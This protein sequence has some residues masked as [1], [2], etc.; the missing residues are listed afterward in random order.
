MGN[1]KPKNPIFPNVPKSMDDYRGW[2]GLAS[3]MRNYLSGF[4]VDRDAPG[5]ITLATPTAAGVG[6]QLHWT[7]TPKAT[8]YHVLRNDSNNPTSALVISVLPGRRNVSFFDP[9]GSSTTAATLYYWIQPFN[10]NVAGPFSNMG[11]IGNPSLPAGGQLNGLPFSSPLGDGRHGS[12]HITTNTT[13]TSEIPIYQVTDLTIDSGVTWTAYA[14]NPGGFYISCT[15]RVTIEGTLTAA[16]RG[17]LGGRSVTSA[18][19]GYHG[20][21]GWNISGSG[22]G[23]G[24]A[25]SGADQAGGHG[26]PCKSGI[27]MTGWSPGDTQRDSSTSTSWFGNSGSPTNNEVRH[28]SGGISNPGGV[29]GLNSG[30]NGTT[31]NSVA[32]GMAGYG[33]TD[34]F[35]ILWASAPGLVYGFG[36]GGG[37]GGLAGAGT[38]SGAGGNGGGIIVILC[39]EFDF[40]ASGTISVAGQNGSN[41]VAAAGQAAGGGGG[42][43]G[44]LIVGYRTLISNV[45]TLTK[46]GGSAGTGA[47]G[48]AQGGAGGD[49]FSKVFDMRI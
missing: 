19:Y 18:G 27:V 21:P 47:L 40:P 44:L 36:G 32:S 15:G 16:N 31:G 20:K 34:L 2:S 42:G 12:I 22:G 11:S 10:E 17:G 30:G 3:S 4:V 26:A 35:N 7:T 23:G 13:A 38:S 37:S 39:N 6:V 41:G 8:S 33:M 5:V 45:G 14:S 49:G 28:Q 29:G 9:V 1:Q 46:T 48:A 25:T 24:G 43:G